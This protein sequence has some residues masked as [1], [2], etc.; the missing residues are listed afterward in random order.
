MSFF[1]F[2]FLVSIV[3]GIMTAVV[4]KEH[5]KRLRIFGIVFV[6]YLIGGF[7]AKQEIAVSI[8]LFIACFFCPYSTVIWWQQKKQRVSSRNNEPKS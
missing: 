5:S 8:A 4:V 7:A 2:I 6:L 3:A 1:L